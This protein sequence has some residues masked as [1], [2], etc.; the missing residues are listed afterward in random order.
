[1]LL[2]KYNNV[3]TC[4]YISIYM[5]FVYDKGSLQS[6]GT[7]LF[8]DSKTCCVRIIV[9]L[10]KSYLSQA[11]QVFKIEQYKIISL[12][13][14]IVLYTRFSVI[15][16]CISGIGRY[17]YSGDRIHNFTNP[18]KILKAADYTTSSTSFKKI[19]IHQCKLIQFLLCIDASLL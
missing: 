18:V 7:F 4:M 11:F 17:S 8:F 6:K 10:W 1:M 13:G 2:Q 9:K 16:A 14:V 15:E 19:L 5:Y 12:P 3:M